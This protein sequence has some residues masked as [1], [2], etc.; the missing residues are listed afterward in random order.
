MHKLVF[1]FYFILGFVLNSQL[2]AQPQNPIVLSEKVGRVIDQSENIKYGLWPSFVGFEY[3][4]FR[5]SG[6]EIFIFFGYRRF[7]KSLTF[8]YQLS[9]QGFI[10]YQQLLSKDIF[11]NE[12]NKST[13]MKKINELEND[14]LASLF[15]EELK[16][17]K[18][19]FNTFPQERPLVNL[20]TQNKHYICQITRLLNKDEIM[21]FHKNKNKVI[22][23]S[24]IEKI[25][26]I[27]D[28]SFNKHLKYGS[29][30]AAF[31]G[32]FGVIL[33]K[34]KQTE[35][36]F[37]ENIISGVIGGV[38][39]GTVVGFSSGLFGLFSEGFNYDLSSLQQ[40]EK[41]KIINTILF[42]D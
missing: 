41:L 7:K 34:S 42:P 26:K 40:I 31:F 6:S 19:M 39:F 9:Q 23:I 5:N 16:V 24:E 33:Q 22:R 12:D 37:K 17:N 25:D 20:F 13:L 29:F 10:L 11:L 3:A 8:K 1:L 28:E 35:T 30:Y 21:I 2:E 14:I 36:N 32:F 38:L 4:T 27:G 15:R 18:I